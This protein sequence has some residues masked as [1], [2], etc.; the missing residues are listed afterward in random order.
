MLHS[1]VDAT[2][3]VKVFMGRNT[4]ELEQSMKRFYE[5]VEYVKPEACRNDST[6]IYLLARRFKG[7]KENP[8]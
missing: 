1:K 5:L 3:L 7:I 4:N 8:S 2:C 6:E